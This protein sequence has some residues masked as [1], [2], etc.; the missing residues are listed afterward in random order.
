VI[1]NTVSISVNLGEWIEASLAAV[2]G[3]RIF[4]PR[5]L[6]PGLKLLIAVLNSASAGS[7]HP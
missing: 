5:E 7:E 3:A 6:D 1:A 2:I 4:N